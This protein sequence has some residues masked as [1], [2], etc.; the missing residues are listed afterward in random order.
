MIDDTVR[1]GASDL[2]IWCRPELNCPPHTPIRNQ[3]WRYASRIGA[4]R[5][6]R[7]QHLLTALHVFKRCVALT[8][9]VM[10]KHD[11]WLG[12]E[13]SACNMNTRRHM[14]VRY[15]MIMTS[16]GRGIL[17]GAQAA[18]DGHS[19][20]MHVMYHVIMTSNERGM[21]CDAQSA[22]GEHKKVHACHVR[23]NHDFL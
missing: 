10:L 8:A 23:R 1:R 20:Y 7:E 22:Q 2:R 16:Y 3:H 9:H 11:C 21:L 14:H 18:E 5:W 13:A 15:H 17:C 4:F 6:A 12:A 19:K